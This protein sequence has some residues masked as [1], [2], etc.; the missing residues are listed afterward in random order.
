MQPKE[1]IKNLH[2][3]TR[4]IVAGSLEK[5]MYGEVSVPIF[6]SSTFAFPSAE[7]GAARFAGTSAG[8]IYTRLDNPTVHALEDGVATLENGFAALAAASGMAAISTVFLTF[9]EQGAHLVSTDSIY[10]ASRVLLE[11]E[12]SRFGVTASFVNTSDLANVRR[13]MQHNTRILYVET[14]T[15][16]T[17][18]ITDLAG[19]AAMARSMACS[20]WWIILSP[21][22]ICSARWNWA[23]MWWCTA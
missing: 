22:P 19:A 9:L 13:A 15:N 2:R 7:E 4:A 1:S 23:P 11:R 6:Q 12:L 20:W 21:A 16:P 14:P 8:Y 17:M 10:G 18:Q 5:N 3:S